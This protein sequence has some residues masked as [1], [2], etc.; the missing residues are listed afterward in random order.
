MKWLNKSR[1]GAW[2]GALGALALAAQAH[3]QLTPFAVGDD[4]HASESDAIDGAGPAPASIGP[5]VIVGDLNG[6][7]RWGTDTANTMTIF[8][9]GTTSCNI[10]TLPLDWV[11]SN[12]RH[13][14]IGQNLYRYKVV[15]GAARFEQ[16]GQSWLKHGFTALAQSLCSPCQNPGT[17]SRLGVGCSDPYSAG[18]NGD[19]TRLGPKNHVNAATGHY[20]YPFTN[21][22]A[23]YV[24]PPPAA[25]TIGR[26][27]QV[28]NTEIDPALNAGAAYYVE[29]QY[30][31]WDEP[32]WGTNH[33]NCA[34]RR[35]TNARNAQN[36]LTLTVSGPTVR[37]KPAIYAWRDVHDSGVEIQEQIIRGDGQ[38]VFA[39]RVTDLGNSRWHYEYAMF[40]NTSHQSG[41]SFSV[42]ICRGA[43]IT[44]V[45]FTDVAYH[46]GEPY[47]SVDWVPEVT[48]TSVTWRVAE[49]FAQNPNANALRWGTQYNFRFIADRPPGG[50][51]SQITLG[52]FRPGAVSQALFSGL[53][54]SGCCPS[55]FD[56]NGQ[57]DFFDYLG[58]A[59]AFGNDEPEADFNN[60]GQVD[61]FDY[62]DFA[63]AFGAGC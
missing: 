43:N 30:V 48:S 52:L 5:D 45:G 44:N 38:F 42:P 27:L 56:G 32:Q 7:T 46:S 31:T 62:L 8:S 41:A 12:N 18:L 23:G 6:V 37:E 40:N 10:G 58:F 51:A 14:V 9:V 25:A 28:L 63:S 60:S 59:N 35:V 55:D 17:G 39:Y 33:N 29:G 4:V 2:V 19:Q 57:V 3:A 21:P 15:N 24:T 50:S 54:P 61:F 26:R 16:I 1:V 11:A 22:G 36:Q 53:S 13:P 20:P 47:D 34:Y 49:T